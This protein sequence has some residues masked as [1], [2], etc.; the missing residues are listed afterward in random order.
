MS[1]LRRVA[2]RLT[3]AI[4]AAL[5]AAQANADALLIGVATPLT[6]PSARLGAQIRAGAQAAAASASP[7]ATLEIVD[8]QCSAEGGAKAANDLVAAKVERGRRLPVHRIDRG[9]DADPQGS[10]HPGDHGRR[11]HQQPDRPQVQDRLAGVPAGAAVRRGNCRGGLDADRAVAAGIVRHHRRRHHL[12][13]RAC[14]DAALGI[15]EERG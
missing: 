5:A 10:R 14:R 3:I 11:A 1:R 7:A 15:R 9:G 13:P 4:V 6:G 2:V 8:D 12:R